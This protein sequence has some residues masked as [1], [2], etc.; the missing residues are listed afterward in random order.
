MT[1]V[2]QTPASH[3]TPRAAA[4][5]TDAGRIDVK[6]RDTGEFIAIVNTLFGPHRFV[7]LGVD[8]LRGRVQGQRVADLIV[9]RLN[10]GTEA[11]VLVEQTRDAW[12][13]THPV[14]ADGAWDGARFMPDELM[15]YAPD[16]CGRIDM[17]GDT[18][19]H[20]TFVPKLAIN[21]HLAD[22]LG[23]P[24]DAP[25]RF[26][27][28]LPISVDAAQRLR[29]LSSMLQDAPGPTPALASAWQGT[30]C[31]E[32]L[33]LWPH[34][35]SEAMARTAPALPRLLRRACDFMH[36][37][38]RRQPEAPLPV[39][40]IARAASV[41]VRALELAFRKHLATTPARY[42]RDQRLNGARADLTARHA[43]QR[44]R[45]ADVSL[46]W[47]FSNPGQFARA[48][49]ERFGELPGNRRT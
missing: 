1:G 30:F 41:G 4:T 43:S 10:Y 25:L 8:G 48:Y 5:S 40:H 29:T 33:S 35:Y 9:G 36:D 17:H 15:M 3:P 31:M 24:H 42:L 39:E 18:W 22:L 7:G 14:G 16:W 44:P 27:H 45:V 2:Q 20:N 21:R 49:R 47:G 6:T 46:K 34:N 32:L 37:H 19:M 11:H 12:V 23:S 28:R 13:M 38:L 26:D